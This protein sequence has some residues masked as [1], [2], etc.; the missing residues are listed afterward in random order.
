MNL[1]PFASHLESQ[2]IGVVGDNIFYYEMPAVVETGILLRESQ[3]GTLID[4]ELP[5]YRKTYFRAV[6]RD[7]SYSAGLALSEQVLE[8]LTIAN[9]SLSNL[10]VKFVRP[11][12]EPIVFPRSEG[13]AVEFSINFEAVYVIN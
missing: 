4:P 10:S 2:G 11:L 9:V 12:N 5:G 7:G 13:D 3:A 6:V 1:E 8:A